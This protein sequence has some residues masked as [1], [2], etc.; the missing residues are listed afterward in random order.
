MKINKSDPSFKRTSNSNKKCNKHKINDI[1]ESP[2]NEL[3]PRRKSHIVLLLKAAWAVDAEIGQLWIRAVI[4]G[5]Y[6]QVEHSLIED[7]P[8]TGEQERQ[9]LGELHSRGKYYSCSE[10]KTTFLIFF[11]HQTLGGK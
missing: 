9:V 1:L 11:L 8:N 4:S 6:L 7:V 3:P 10:Y 5:S 2:L